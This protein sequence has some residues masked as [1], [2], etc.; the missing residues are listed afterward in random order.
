MITYWNFLGKL[1]S[2]IKRDFYNTRKKQVNKGFLVALVV[3]VVVVAG[4]VGLIWK[5]APSMEERK[6]QVFEGAIRE[7]SPEFAELT[8]KIIAENDEE[9]TW[10]SPLGTGFIMMNIAGKIRNNS[11]KVITGLEIQVAVL[12]SFGKVVKDKVLLIVPNQQARLEPK[13]EMNVV[14]RIDNF[15]RDDDRARVQ[16]KVTAIKTAQ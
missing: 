4:G 12:D 13:G 7:D 10:Q 2:N 1:L 14:V 6:Q 5:F 3:A 15:N 16:W 11:D 9:N 8:K